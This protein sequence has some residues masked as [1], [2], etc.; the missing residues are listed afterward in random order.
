MFPDLLKI[1]PPGKKGD[2]VIKKITVTKEESLRSLMGLDA[3]LLYCEAGDYLRLTIGNEIVMSNTRMEKNT[4]WDVVNKANGLVLIAGLGIA[5]IIIPILQKENVRRVVVVEKNPNVIDLVYPHVK[6]PK[7]EMV[8][9]DI[10][11]WVPKKGTKFDTIYF[12]IWN[13]INSKNLP[14]MRRLSIRFKPYFNSKNP[15]RFIDSWS[16]NYLRYERRR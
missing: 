10:F 7:L 13:E 4:N 5:L 11:E 1:I 8:R 14:E 3:G 16:R 12:D 6:H 15:D 9:G 2:V